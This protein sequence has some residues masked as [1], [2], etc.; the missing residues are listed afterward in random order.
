MG[1]CTPNLKLACFVCYLKI[2][3]TFSKNIACI[4]KYIYIKSIYCLDQKLKNRLAYV[5]FEFLKAEQHPVVIFTMFCS[6]FQIVISFFDWIDMHL[7]ENFLRNTKTSFKFEWI[8]WFLKHW[9]QCGR[10]SSAYSFAYNFLSLIHNS[11]KWRHYVSGEPAAL[12]WCIY[13]PLM[14]KFEGKSQKIYVQTHAGSHSE[15]I[16]Y[17]YRRVTLNFIR[18]LPV[19]W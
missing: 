18:K 15:I 16:S 8:N 3:N 19:L 17:Y 9:S 12:K 6:L 1:Y 11:P 5:I 2:I 7:K 14:L 4:L 10:D 13:C